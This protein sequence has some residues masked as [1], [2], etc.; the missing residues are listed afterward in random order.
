MQ[1]LSPKQLVFLDEAGATTAMT[2]T[3]ARAIRGERVVD[4]VPQGKWQVTT[5]IGAMRLSGSCAGL[6]FEGAT[7]TAAFMAFLENCLV[8]QLKK[9]DVVVMDNLSSHKS[10]RVEPAITAVGARVRYLPPYSPD[11]NPIE[12][13][14]SKVKGSLRTAAKRTQRTLWNAIGPAMQS[15]TSQDC[16]GYFS[17]CGLPAT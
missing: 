5:M 2:R 6:V 9:G 12:K 10:A 8:P 1:K 13:M 3:Y 11:F 14:W 15:I 7:D 16:K 17:A 4:A